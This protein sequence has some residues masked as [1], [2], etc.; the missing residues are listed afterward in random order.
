LQW[1]VAAKHRAG[2]R[3]VSVTLPVLSLSGRNVVLIDDMAASGFTLSECARAALAA[4]ARQVDAVVCHAL[5]SDDV[6]AM[7]RAAGI[8]SIRS[9]DS[10]PHASNAALLAGLLAAALSQ[11]L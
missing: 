10:V 6:A 2:D 5:F 4:G 11:L 3:N 8:R 9:T 7:L 1:G